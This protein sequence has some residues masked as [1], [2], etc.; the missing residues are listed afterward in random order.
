MLTIGMFTLLVVFILL[1]API[2]FVM[3][4]LPMAYILITDAVPMSVVPYQMYDSLGKIPLI[5]VPL[6]LFAGELMNR[7]EV[8]NRLLELSQVAVGR[9]RGGV[10]QVTVVLSMLFATLNGSAVASTVTIGSIMIPAMKRSGYNA[11]YS[12]ALT[13]AASTIGAIIPP[14]LPLIIFASATNLSVGR[15]FSAGVL[16]GILIGLMFMAIAYI[17][18]VRNKHERNEQSFGF[19]RLLR[20][21]QRSALALLL[22]LLLYFGIVLGIVSATEAGAFVAFL[23]FVIGK[24]VYKALT[25]SD[26]HSALKQTVRS[27]ASIFLIIAAA[28]PFSWLLTR[29]G[30]LDALEGFLLRFQDDK[31]LF[32]LV[33]VGIIFIAGMLMDIVANLLILGPTLLAAGTAAGLESTQAA[34][35]IC[36]GFILGTITPPVG[37]CYF[38]AAR[39]AAASL[40]SVAL[41]LVPFIAAE[42]LLLFLILGFPWLT[43]WLPKLSGF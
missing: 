7:G 10:S 12:A 43:Q 13:G 15:L 26:V 30:A 38:A 27:T 42:T 34:M 19:V 41:K 24:F 21:L 3:A 5:A 28:G 40:E 8:T 39:I 29:L 14:S 6:F 23:A 32:I 31:I 16:P 9:I 17:V 37:I 22:P 20:A 2:G 35:V 25:W 1:G 18:A 36:V 4:I 11:S 33:F